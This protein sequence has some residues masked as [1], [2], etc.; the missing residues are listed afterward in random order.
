MKSSCA[1]RLKMTD[2]FKIIMKISYGVQRTLKL[3]ILHLE[4]CGRVEVG[5]RRDLLLL[6]ARDRYEPLFSEQLGRV[7]HTVARLA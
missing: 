3:G 7:P 1:Y 6:R 4:I 5:P 2:P